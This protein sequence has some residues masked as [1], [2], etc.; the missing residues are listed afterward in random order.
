MYT[1][2]FCISLDAVSTT[3]WMHQQNSNETNGGKARW[4]LHQNATCY[5]E[6]ILEAAPHKINCTA[7]YLSSSKPFTLD[8]LYILS[9]A[10]EVKTNS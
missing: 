10:L 1:S 7:A 8:E 3:V 5:F 4:E 6:K 9:T 2:S